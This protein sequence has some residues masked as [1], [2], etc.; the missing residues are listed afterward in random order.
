MGLAAVSEAEAEGTSS[1]SGEAAAAV[2]AA[3]VAGVDKPVGWCAEMVRVE[4]K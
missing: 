4:D 3:V 2:A 1:G